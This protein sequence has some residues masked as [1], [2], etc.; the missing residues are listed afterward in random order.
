MELHLKIIGILLIALSL[1]H[2][3]FPNYFKWKQELSS[4]NIMNRQMMYVHSSF[5]AFVVFLM[6]LLCLT[7]SE[8]LLTTE[9]GKRISLGLG[10]FWIARL[11][12]QLFGYSSKVWKGKTFETTVHILFSL[13][14]IYLSWTFIMIYTK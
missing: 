10:I 6:G 3:G 14:W 13:F 8:E 12:V 9:L 7:S 11:L 1:I 4:L 5:I 2:V